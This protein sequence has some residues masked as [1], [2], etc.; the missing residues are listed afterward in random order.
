M[1]HNLYHDDETNSD[2]FFSV[3]G[4]EEPWHGLG[5]RIPEPV[6]ASKAV[7]LIRADR[8][9][10]DTVPLYAQDGD[11]RIPIPANVAIVGRL[12][13]KNPDGSPA[14]DPVYGIATPRY[15]PMQNKDAAALWDGVTGA[16]DRLRI[17]T[18]GMLGLGE[19]MWLLAEL[20]P[21]RRLFLA[22]DETKKY[23]LLSVEHT[24]KGANRMLF[25]PIRV[26]CQN[27]LSMAL[28]AREEGIWIPHFGDMASRIEAAKDALGFAIKMYDET[29]ANA[30]RLLRWK[31]DQTQTNRILDVMY[32]DPA[33]NPET[34][35]PNHAHE[36]RNEIRAL[37]VTGKGQ[38]SRPEIIG[39]GWALYNGAVEYLDYRRRGTGV[40]ANAESRL[41]AR[42]FGS[43]AAL[44]TRLWSAMMDMAPPLPTV[45][46]A[47]TPN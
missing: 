24:G 47:D 20:D 41:N 45:I 7:E 9:K 43:G 15:Q 42:W 23:L 37:A 16:D 32:P 1:A 35:E 3:A 19:R 13:R 27:T 39:T 17:R 31:P 28:G 36:A 26:V 46:G 29:E 40:R 6:P 25:T 33:I 44:K 4:Q 5:L 21:D 11:R 12:N 30:D 38:A 34:N 22:G 2:A 10:I 8:I 18:A 14:L